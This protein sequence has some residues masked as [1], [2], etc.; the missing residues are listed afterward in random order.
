[1]KKHFK[2][3][4]SLAVAGLLITTG[5][6][7]KAE[8]DQ[9]GPG[10]GPR[11]PMF[12]RPFFSKEDK[13]KM[14]ENTEE[15]RQK[16]Q[17]MHKEFTDKL[18]TDRETFKAKLTEE[19]EAF[20]SANQERRREFWG[21][22]GQMIGQRFAMV[23]KMLENAQTRVGDAIDK[24]KDDGKDTTDAANYLKLSKEKLADAKAKLEDLKKLVPDSGDKITQEIFAQIK[25]AAREAKDLLKE[26]KE[27][28][29]S[30][31]KEIKDLR[32]EHDNGKDNENNN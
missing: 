17:D 21:H 4:L 16:M 25:E 11:G 32:G 27:D 20:K 30:A 5:A 23:I 14:K 24:L 3:V 10:K 7:A 2:L 18:K 9:V 31:I 12:E 22:V 15:R 28:L 1:M 6:I 26:S 19:K 8:E 13:T 29:K